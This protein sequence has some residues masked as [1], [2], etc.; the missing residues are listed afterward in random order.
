MM[1]PRLYN[2]YTVY[3]A[4]FI[5]NPSAVKEHSTAGR[6]RCKTQRSRR[7]NVIVR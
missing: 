5:E 2:I 3:I 4:T 1:V 7:V 6:L